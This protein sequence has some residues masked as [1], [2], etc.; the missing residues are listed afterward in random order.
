[1]RLQLGIVALLAS[2]LSLVAARA[3]TAGLYARTTTDVCGDVSD[4]LII[5][6]LFGTKIP[7]GRIGENTV[8]P[9]L[10]VVLNLLSNARQVYLRVA[11]PQ[12]AEDRPA[13]P[14]GES[15]CRL[16]PTFSF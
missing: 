9:V 5:P 4:E 14:H 10:P 2:G 11:D 3:T 13:P 8:V 12:L 15:F 7:I 1:M 16:R 6:G